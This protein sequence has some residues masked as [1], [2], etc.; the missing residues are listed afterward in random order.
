[1]E[2]LKLYRLIR[3]LF[4]IKSRSFCQINL[5]DYANNSAAANL[6]NTMRFESAL[7]Q[8]QGPNPSVP[9]PVEGT[10]ATFNAIKSKAFSLLTR[11]YD[12]AELPAQSD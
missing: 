8:A 5:S 11:N 7:R 9:V 10:C 1:M 3:I 12:V 6:N 4:N 2:S